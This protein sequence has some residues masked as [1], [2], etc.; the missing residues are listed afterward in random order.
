MPEATPRSIPLLRIVRTLWHHVWA[1]GNHE[2]RLRLE[3]LESQILTGQ[4]DEHGIVTPKLEALGEVGTLQGRVTRASDGQPLGGI[5]VEIDGRETRSQTT[6]SSGFY[7]FQDLQA[8]RYFAMARDADGYIDELFDDI[9]CPFRPSAGCF[10]SDG[11]PIEVVNLGT[12]QVDFELDPGGSISGN[13]T[14]R[15]NGEPFRPLVF[16]DLWNAN[17]VN[18]ATVVTNAGSYRF[19][20]LPAGDYF[21]TV[22]TP[23][24][25]D[26]LFDDIPC[27]V[28][29]GPICELIPDAAIRVTPGNETTGIDFDMEKLGS[30]AGQVTDGLTGEPIPFIYLDAIGAQG[31]FQGE[32]IGTGRTNEMGEFS[33]GGLYEGSYYVNTYNFQGFDDELY[34]NQPC[35]QGSCD[36]AL[37]QPVVVQLE[38]TTPGIDFVLNGG[39]VESA[40]VMC[41]NQNRFRIDAKWRTA[42][43][44]TGSGQAAELTDDSGYFWFFGSNNIEMVVKV[45]DACTLPGANNFWVFAGGLTDVEVTLTVTDTRTG[46]VKTYA[47]PLGSPFQP[48]QD[49]S[50]FDTC[51]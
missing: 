1:S 33:I 7:S 25:Q 46:Q 13:L 28:S 29:D 26:E 14:Y 3:A 32:R 20:S 24:Y 50:A 34:D 49:T 19:T 8:G 10:L 21:V 11:T 42:G 35:P 12:T 41:L 30:I 37:G 48:I 16:L 2:L 15:G 5:E 4:K 27:P 36:L 31:T 40:E 38:Q 18:L 9:P 23:D 43:G 51:P 45:L 47:N 17:R 6:D 44:T 22:S 39:C